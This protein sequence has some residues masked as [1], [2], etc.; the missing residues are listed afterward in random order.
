M[1]LFTFGCSFTEGQGLKK[2]EEK[3]YTILL[4]EK[5][6]IEY[7]NFGSA[8]MPND[9]NHLAD[10]QMLLTPTIQIKINI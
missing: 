6:G 3:E 1:T 4:A 9:S 2:L 8:G 5:L 7:Y 10:T